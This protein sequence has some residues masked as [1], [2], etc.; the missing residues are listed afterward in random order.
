MLRG[1]R[2]TGV[3]SRRDHLHGFRPVYLLSNRRVDMNG[4]AKRLVERTWPSWPRLCD[5]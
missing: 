3:I 4:P 1:L 5:E 2:I